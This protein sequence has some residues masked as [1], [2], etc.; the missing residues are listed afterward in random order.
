MLCDLHLQIK[1]EGQ[2]ILSAALWQEA[3]CNQDHNLT[4][5]YVD[6]LKS[7]IIFYTFSCL[8]FFLLLPKPLLGQTFKGFRGN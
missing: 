6:L 1:A 3:D 7:Q 8:S 5:K 4:S 2:R